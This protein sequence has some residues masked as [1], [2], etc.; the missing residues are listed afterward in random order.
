MLCILSS[1]YSEE[2][3]IEWRKATPCAI[4]M[5]I[6]T[7]VAHDKTSFSVEGNIKREVIY[8][9]KLYMPIYRIYA[10]IRRDLNFRECNDPKFLCASIQTPIVIFYLHNSNPKI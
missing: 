1:K 6:L 10:L 8:K 3:L 2:L 9:A 5:A 4:P 7:R